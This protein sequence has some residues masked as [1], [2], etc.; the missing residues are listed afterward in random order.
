MPRREGGF[1]QFLSLPS[2]HVS[3]EVTGGITC[4]NKYD[5]WEISSPIGG[6]AR[7]ETACPMTCASVS[8]LLG[9]GPL[10]GGG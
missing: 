1:F 4:K 7:Y 8:V 6:K 3:Y 10:I 5:E 2:E 9:P